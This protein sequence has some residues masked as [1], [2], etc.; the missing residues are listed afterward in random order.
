[1]L[2]VIHLVK[3]VLIHQDV[4]QVVLMVIEKMDG[5]AQEC[6]VSDLK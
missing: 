4:A 2:H 6:S 5:N 1:V 3:H